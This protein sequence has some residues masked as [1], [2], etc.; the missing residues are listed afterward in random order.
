VRQ[1]V[2][3]SLDAFLIL[4]AF[5]KKC[6]DMQGFWRLPVNGDVRVVSPDSFNELSTG[7]N[8]ILEVI[9]L[10][11]FLDGLQ[12]IPYG[13]PQSLSKRLRRMSVCVKS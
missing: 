5:G 3:R 12:N 4:I 9:S 13:G 10:I 8:V 1:G 11:V 7:L 6:M 2:F